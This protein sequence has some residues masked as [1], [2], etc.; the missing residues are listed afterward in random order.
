MSKQITLGSRA[1]ND[2][3]YQNPSVSGYHAVLKIENNVVIIEDLNI[4]EN[5]LADRVSMKEHELEQKLQ[6]I[7]ITE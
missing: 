7:S 5:Q 2:F 4:C 1:D 3:S 6:V